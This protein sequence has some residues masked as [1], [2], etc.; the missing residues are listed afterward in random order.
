MAVIANTYKT[1]D[2]KGI[3]EDLSNVISNI[4][5]TDTPVQSNAGRGPKPKNTFYEWQLDSLAAADAT[6]AQLEGDDVAA[7]DAEVPTTRVGNY[8]QISRKTM[9]LSDTQE[10]VDKAGRKSE[11][12]YQIS[13]K[14]KEMKRDIEKTVL[15]NHG[16]V[17][18]AAGTARKTATLLSYIQTNVDKAGDGANPAAPSP[19]YAGTRTDGTQRAFTET[20]PKNIVQLAFTT[21][22]NVDG[23]T[24]MLGTVQK[25]VASTFSGI[26]TKFQQTKGKA[27]TIIGAADVYV[28]DF[29]EISI[30]PN[31]F[32]R[33][34]DAFLLDWDLVSFR[35]LRPYRVTDLAKTGDA[36]KKMLLR[37]WTLQV[38]NEAGLA[39]A[40]DLV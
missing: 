39:G 16:A 5:P 36:T 21:G 14:G 10:E 23:A 22:M 27:A 6:N 37:E 29:G 15:D 32:Q 24:L 28:S 11:L 7:F 13:K 25:Q 3:R 35:D 26:A 1:Y 31:R 8:T 20:I 30:V 12:A 38:E 2:M 34:R 18:G 33:N 4:S 9:I 40:F 17:A 19:A